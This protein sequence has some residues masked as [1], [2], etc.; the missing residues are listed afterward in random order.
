MRGRT[1][2]R[3]KKVLS[4]HWLKWKEIVHTVFLFK[5]FIYEVW[6]SKLDI[7][8]WVTSFRLCA[9]PVPGTCFRHKLV[10]FLQQ[11]APVAT[12]DQSMQHCAS[13]HTPSNNDNI[14]IPVHHFNYYWLTNT[15]TSFWATKIKKM[16]IFHCFKAHVEQ[17][18]GVLFLTLQ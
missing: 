9:S 17:M 4:K 10:I 15:V 18:N 3:N 11:R 2:E 6:T 16:V 5:Y 12:T 8:L 7:I 1:A 14:I 13:D